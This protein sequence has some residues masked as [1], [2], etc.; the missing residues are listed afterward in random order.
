MT[1][2]DR[3]E[4]PEPQAPEQVTCEICHRQLPAEEALRREVD[5]Y[6]L[7]FCGQDCFTRWRSDS[8]GGRE[9]TES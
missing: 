1:T 6:V 7:W 8:S 5:D 2:S 4:P 9:E 3:I